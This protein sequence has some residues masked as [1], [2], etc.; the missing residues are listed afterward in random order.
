MPGRS[1]TSAN[2]R[3]GFNGKELDPE[4]MGGGG[5][6]YDYGF[7]IYNPNLGRFLSVDPLSIDY[8]WYTPYQ[9]AGNTPIWAIDLDG[10]EEYFVTEKS[11]TE[12]G[13]SFERL[14][15]RN[16]AFA[17]MSK[18]DQAKNLGYIQFKINGAP[19]GPIVPLSEENK[20]DIKLINN[21]GG[22][23]EDW[24]HGS[25]LRKQPLQ[26]VTSKE[27]E[28]KIDKPITVKR[29]PNNS[30]EQIL[31]PFVASEELMF[32]I[33]DSYENGY[34]KESVGFYH[35]V[36]EIVKYLYANP[37]ANMTI[38]MD[39]FHAFNKDPDIP[40]NWSDPIKQGTFGGKTYEDL[41][42]LRYK[43]I[44]DAVKK[45][46]N[47]GIKESRFKLEKGKLDGTGTTTF[48]PEKSKSK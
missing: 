48:T 47:G 22:K 6:T 2:Y 31:P 5:S 24:P 12:T 11:T 23:N 8:P 19:S 45:V 41:V 26:K 40:K 17:K 20:A 43:E 16:P 13:Y 30:K 36:T 15:E 29:A 37:N 4:G 28:T 9:F 3:Y 38:K 42:N 7:R 46:T 32:T 10:L 18:E 14:Y 27:T 44:V 25:V 35:V 21:A 33:S 39:G 1:F 34:K